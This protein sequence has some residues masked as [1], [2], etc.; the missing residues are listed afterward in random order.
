MPFFFWLNC[1]RKFEAEKKT[2]TWFKDLFGN[3]VLVIFV[4]FG[5]ICEGKS[6]KIRVMLFKNWKHIFKHMY[7]TGSKQVHF[8]Y[9][10]LLKLFLTGNNYWF[11]IEKIFTTM[12][13]VFPPLTCACQEIFIFILF[14]KSILLF[15][16]NILLKKNYS[17]Y[18]LFYY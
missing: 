5:N 14:L 4:F 3:V 10:V 1:N 8:L 13:G 12:W 6:V 7:Q 9:Y 16:F 17:I 15:N 11:Q 2:E 18:I